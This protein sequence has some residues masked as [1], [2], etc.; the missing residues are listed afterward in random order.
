MGGIKWYIRVV[1]LFV[2]RQSTVDIST[3]HGIQLTTTMY[4]KELKGHMYVLNTTYKTKP[5]KGS[6]NRRLRRNNGN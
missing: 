3:K 6:A 2:K 4:Y 1:L 5:A